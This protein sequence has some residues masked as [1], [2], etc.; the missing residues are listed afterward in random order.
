LPMG[1][2]ILEIEFKQNTIVKIKTKTNILRKTANKITLPELKTNYTESDITQYIIYP[3]TLFFTDK[4]KLQIAIANIQLELKQELIKLK[5]QKKIVEYE[6][7]KKRTNYDI[8]MLKTTGYCSGIENYSRHLNFKNAGDPPF[9]LLGYYHYKFNN[10][11]LIFIDE[12]HI[13]IPQLQGMYL[14]D[15][16]RKETLINFGFRLPSALDNRPLKFSEF[17]K[18]ISQVIYT[19]ATPKD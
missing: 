16:S 4:Q 18:Q 5:K 15:R 19:S 8:E 13:A 1:N 6:R 17:E 3:A 11:F 10:D 7:L 2:E 14:G 9:T 12:S